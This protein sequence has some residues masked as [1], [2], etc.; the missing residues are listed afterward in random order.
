MKNIIRVITWNDQPLYWNGESLSF[1]KE[2]ESA[3]ED[4]NNREW[5][6]AATYARHQPGYELMQLVSI[7]NGEDEIHRKVNNRYEYA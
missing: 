1:K 4:C 2:I 6:R 5:E 3:T 7:R